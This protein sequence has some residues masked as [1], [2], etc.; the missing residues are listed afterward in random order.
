MSRIEPRV[1]AAEAGD[2]LG[3]LPLPVARHAG[4]ADD[5]ARAHVESHVPHRV[6]PPVAGDAKTLDHQTDL[7]A[8]WLG[9]SLGRGDLAAHH[10]P[11]QI[12]PGDIGGDDRPDG[13]TDVRDAP[14]DRRDDDD[15]A[16]PLLEH[17]RKRGPDAVEDPEDVRPDD[18]VPARRVGLRDRTEVGDRGVR[19]EDIQPAESLDGALD[20]ALRMRVVA[21]VA[22]LHDDVGGPS[23]DR[24]RDSV[25]R[26]PPTAGQDESRAIACEVPC[27]GRADAGP[28]PGDQ[29]PERIRG[30]RL[31]HATPHQSMA[32][33]AY[34]LAA[35]TTSAIATLS[36]TACANWMLPGPQ[37]T[38]GMPAFPRYVASQ[39]ASKPRIERIGPIARPGG[40]AGRRATRA[41]HGRRQLVLDGQ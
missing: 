24:R 12:V 31:R 18:R 19:D 7:V 6:H 28:R 32:A 9:G 33:S 26:L 15:V 1:G 34:T 35:S 36:S 41:R 3:E 17:D 30:A 40:I 27:D 23:P 2:C 14:R 5:L 25:E 22:G 8:S 29:H 20:E 10:H 21:H 37:T 16:V 11:G 39:T 13:L 4:D 38:L